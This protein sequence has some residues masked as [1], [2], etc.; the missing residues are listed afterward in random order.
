M[1]NRGDIGA[2]NIAD[3]INEA[4]QG[5]SQR[6]VAEAAGKAQLQKQSGDVVNSRM[7]QETGPMTKVFGDIMTTLTGITKNPLY[8]GAK[9]LAELLI[10][11]FFLRKIAKNTDGLVPAAGKSD[12]QTGV[13]DKL[14]KKTDDKAATA[15]TTL[16]N[17]PLVTT[18]G[19]PKPTPT[20]PGAVT[21]K[22]PLAMTLPMPAHAKNGPA[23]TPPMPKAGKA[24]LG[25]IVGKIPGVGN[26]GKVGSLVSSVLTGDITAVAG[27]LMETVVGSLTTAG[28]AAAAA[29]EGAVAAGGGMMAAAGG[30]AQSVLGALPGMLGLGAAVAAV[31]GAVEEGMTGNLAAAGLATQ[32]DDIDTSKKGWMGDL[33]KMIWEKAGGMFWGAIRGVGAAITGGIDW[34]LHGIGVDTED[35]FG[36]TLTNLFD[37]AFAR[38]TI[39]WK[40]FKKMVF[41]GY[42]AISKLFGGNWFGDTIKELDAEIT[43]TEQSVSALQEDGKATLTS[44]GEANNKATED[45]KKQGKKI[46]VGVATST[47]DLLAQAHQTVATAQAP[48]IAARDKAEA[49]AK[50][51]V[52]ATPVKAEDSLAPGETVMAKA[53]PVQAAPVSPNAALA[54]PGRQG[55]QNVTPPEVNKP[56]VEEDTDEAKKKALTVV[57]MKEALELLKKQLEVAQKMLDAT[58]AK[59]DTQPGFLRHVLPTFPDTAELT[60]RAV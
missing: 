59:E 8:D 13:L 33:T 17:K 22:T 21:P 51:T 32:T 27:T 54:T 44:I 19:I 50:K 57:G 2:Q 49:E 56:Q 58:T 15:T 42:N 55:R 16:G 38:I 37:I 20:V 43:T 26:L 4:I 41:G 35:L 36:G 46:N 31:W 39:G 52:Q 30:I 29:A 10:Q 7:G 40:S 25:S 47:K 48:A 24:G 14:K 1:Q 34:L 18:G 53:T 5:S 11:T 3:Q 45:A 6:D 12:V 60:R 23:P 9:Q 28:P